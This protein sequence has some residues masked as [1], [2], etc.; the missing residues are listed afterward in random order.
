MKQPVGRTGGRGN[1]GC[2]NTSFTVEM[3]IQIPDEPASYNSFLRRQESTTSRWQLDFD[4]GN[5][6]AFGRG[7]VRFDTPDGDNTNYVTGPT[8][9]ATISGAD[10]LWVDT[11]SGDGLVGS[12][13]DPVN[14]AL[15]GDGINDNLSWHHVAV[16]FDQD[17]QEISYY[18][19][20]SL[21]QSRTLVDN[22]GSGY[23]HPSGQIV[24]GKSG[25]EFGTFID[26]VRYSDG[27]LGPS[28][29]LV[30]SNVPEPGSALLAL[31]GTAGLFVRRK[32]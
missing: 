25:P 13:D 5:K 29:F 17:A 26:E 3:F 15:D 21:M 18:F 6:G 27:L 32:R 31:L 10:R 28:E 23:V 9:G 30:A 22:D 11:D 16:T 7:R 19:D 24:I 20:Y 1:G 2:F 12:Y 4:H 8:G 14:W